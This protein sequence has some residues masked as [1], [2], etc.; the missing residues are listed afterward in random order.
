MLRHLD[1][2]SGIGGFALGFEWAGV[3]RPVLFCDIEPWCRDVLRKHWPSVPIKEDVKELANDPTQIPDHDILSAGY[4]CQP[5]S[6]SGQRKGKADDRH[7]WP[8][9]RRVVALKRP[10][11]VVLENVAGHITM[12]LDEVLADLEAEGYASR[13]FVLPA[14]GVDAPH[15]RDRVWIIAS[16]VGD[17]DSGERQ[18]DEQTTI[19]GRREQGPPTGCQDVPDTDSHRQQ[20]P[21]E[22]PREDRGHEAG[23]HTGWSG[24]DVADPDGSRSKA[25]LPRSEPGQEGFTGEPDDRRHQ[26]GRR[27]PD[28]LWTAEPPVRRVVNGLP[29]RVDRIKGLG[30]AIV[31][32][33]AEQIGLAIKHYEE[34]S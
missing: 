6:Y 34:R 14:C 24:E 22:R 21:S 11:W 27:T 1:L 19:T 5:F 12:G 16:H 2:C 29:R 3:S 8:Y 30:N 13:T 4:P 31:P 33:I 25:R 32:Q 23:D 28:G 10:T 9:I 18:G 20:C 7:L 26:R 15:R 17:P